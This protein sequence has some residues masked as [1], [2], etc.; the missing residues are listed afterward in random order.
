MPRPRLYSDDQL[1]DAALQVL[2]NKGPSAFTLSDV[3][4]AIGMSRA[5]V[6]QRFTDKATLHRRVMEKLTREVVD[7]FEAHRV[8]TG[9]G[10][11]RALLADLISGMGSGAGMEGYLLLMWGDVRD[12]ALRKLAAERNRLVR[13]AIEIR[14]PGGASVA[15]QSA[16]II[17]AVIQGSCMQWLVEPH[18]DL[19]EFMLRQTL[20]ALD[21]LYPQT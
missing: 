15:A 13:Q 14:L 5:A 3:A 2:L 18:G 1:L 11:V 16:S 8:E 10:P 12:P 20:Q 19:S 17:Q 21:C 4:S 7:Y 6:I 9:L